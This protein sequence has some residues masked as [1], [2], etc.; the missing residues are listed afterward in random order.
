MYTFDGQSS[1]RCVLVL[2]RGRDGGP[3]VLG[4]EIRRPKTKVT[5]PE[6]RSCRTAPVMMR[7]TSSLVQPLPAELAWKAARGIR[8]DDLRRSEMHPDVLR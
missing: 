7:R 1:P 5:M 6:G 3:G 4:D 8:L 2:V